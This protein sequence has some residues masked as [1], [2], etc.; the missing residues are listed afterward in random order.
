MIRLQFR[1]KDQHICRTRLAV[2]LI[3]ETFSRSKN[4]I[5]PRRHPQAPLWWQ[6]IRYGQ[7]KNGLQNRTGTQS[8]NAVSDSGHLCPSGVRNK[9]EAPKKVTG[10]A[11]NIHPGRWGRRLPL[12]VLHQMWQRSANTWPTTTTGRA[13]H[14]AREAT[15]CSRLTSRPAIPSCPFRGEGEDGH[16]GRPP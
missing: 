7:R 5:C 10:K 13:G 14:V 1:S 4:E 16:A 6:R 11:K 8:A 9:G 12:R 2:V 15:F 3:N